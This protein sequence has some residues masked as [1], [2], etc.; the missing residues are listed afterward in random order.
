MVESGR[1]WKEYA[2]KKTLAAP[3]AIR[4]LKPQSLTSETNCRGTHGL[5]L[6]VHDMQQGVEPWW[7]KRGCCA[8]CDGDGDD[9]L[10]CGALILVGSLKL[11][12]GESI[13]PGVRSTPCRCA[14]K[15]N[16]PVFIGAAE[17]VVWSSKR[18]GEAER[19]RS[20]VRPLQFGGESALGGHGHVAN[21][22][23]R[24]NM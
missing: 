9:P 12:I 5:V 15:T 20:G 23:L 24:G 6:L 21:D 4:S 2:S 13:P 8:D 3:N 7:R 11:V 14:T 19:G 1:W 22:P 10:K 17:K 18:G 16:W